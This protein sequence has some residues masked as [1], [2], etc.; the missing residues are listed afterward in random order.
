M[1]VNILSCLLPAPALKNFTSDT[2]LF[3]STNVCVRS[4][5]LNKRVAPGHAELPGTPAPEPLKTVVLYSY[6]KYTPG[7]GTWE[8]WIYF[9]RPLQYR[10]E[11]TSTA[12]TQTR[13]TGHELRKILQLQGVLL[14]SR[15]KEKTEWNFPQRYSESEKLNNR[16]W[17]IKLH[18]NFCKII[19]HKK[20]V[21]ASI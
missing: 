13:S 18:Q 15:L 1:Q 19:P 9:H 16:S 7:R 11:S 2:W 8:P 17:K 21:A 14:G 3:H 5:C 4:V 10:Q 20:L 12:W 6:R